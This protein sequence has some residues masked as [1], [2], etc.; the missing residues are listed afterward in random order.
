M[1]VRIYIYI[2]LASYI[3]SVLRLF[4]DNNFMIS[5]IGSFFFGFFI[6]RR[7]STSMNKILLTGFCSCFTSFSGFIYVLYNL[8]KREDLIQVFIYINLTIFLNL[9]FM[10]CGFLMSRKIN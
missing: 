5:I 6:A 10:Y 8:L 4:I 9:V 1:N 3:A 2:L 7:L